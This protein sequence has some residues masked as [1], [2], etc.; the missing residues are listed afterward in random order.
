MKLYEKIELEIMKMLETPPYSEG[1]YLPTELKI[2]EMFSVSRHSVRKAMDN[3]LLKDIIIRE[4]GKGTRL[5]L[6][7]LQVTTTFKSWQSLSDEEFTREHRF[8]YIKKN[9]YSSKLTEDIKKT[10]RLTKDGECVVLERTMSENKVPSV[11]F[12]SYFNPNLLLQ[13]DQDFMEGNFTKLY[14]FLEK[15][16]N[17]QLKLSDETISAI[18]PSKT[19]K[20]ILKIKDDNIPILL[21]KRIVLDKKDRVIEYNFCYYRGDMFNYNITISK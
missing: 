8:T 10:F 6:N 11:H 16:Y 17:I 3:I 5:N 12:I 7:P 20:K 18:M 21:R 14:G 2:C 4:K 1:V 19:I 13:E 9:I 15:N